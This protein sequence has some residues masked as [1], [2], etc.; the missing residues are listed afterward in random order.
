MRNK[1]RRLCG[2]DSDEEEDI[3]KLLASV[4]ADI[5]TVN[6]E[7]PEIIIS[8]SIKSR[9]RRYNIFTMTSKEVSVVVSSE[10]YCKYFSGER[11]ILYRVR[12]EKKGMKS[13]MFKLFSES[14][15]NEVLFNSWYKNNDTNA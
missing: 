8:P 10:G 5:Y 6:N 14:E 13:L 4:P 7:M 15:M 2:F 12:G 3:R 9:G 1:I 11:F